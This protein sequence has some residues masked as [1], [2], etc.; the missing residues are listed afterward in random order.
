MEVNM[1]KIAVLMSTYNGEQ[2]IGDQLES[3]FEQKDV[4]LEILVR[5]DGSTDMT[6]NIL[7]SH[8]SKKKLTWYSGKNL[9]SAYSFL[10]L[11]DNA[12]EADYYA[13]CDQDDVWNEYKLSRAIEKIE[14]LEIES[15][16][17]SPIVYCSDY[18]L[19]DA[20]LNKLSSKGHFSTTSFQ[21]SIVV[22][23]ATG[24]TMVFNNKMQKLL[25]TYKPKHLLM[26]D[27]W[28]HK[29][30]LA[31]G[32][33]VYYDNNYKSLCYRQHDN[34]VDGGVH[35]LGKRIRGIISRMIAREKI[36]SLQLNEVREG[37]SDIIPIDNLEV[38][39]LFVNYRWSLK[40][41]IR[42]LTMKKL[43]TENNSTNR[44]FRISIIFGYY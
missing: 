26:H 40:K 3:L 15:A 12:P 32:G 10:D 41:K 23:N 24:G 44:K 2:F 27:D 31:V 6:K 1:K 37:F 38:L 19:V 33:Y 25:K 13:F 30:C 34:N 18:Q 21:S 4:E 20:D 42:I 22:S 43:A 5:D 16:F 28:T 14:E 7:N 29:V 8:Q 11:V 17:D 35:T 9:K 36:R 39:N